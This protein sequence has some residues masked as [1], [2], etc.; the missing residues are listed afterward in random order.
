MKNRN[1][2]RKHFLSI[3]EVLDTRIR[4]Q[5]IKGSVSKNNT[6]ISAVSGA[7]LSLFGQMRKQGTERLS[8]L[9]KVTQLL[10]GKARV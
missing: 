9:P 2:T 5:I 4:Q 8:H 1:K 3:L 7:I 6:N 10:S